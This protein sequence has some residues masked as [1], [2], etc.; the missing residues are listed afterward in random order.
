MGT[1]PP[2]VFPGN[3]EERDAFLRLD[4]T[5]RRGKDGRT[6]VCGTHALLLDERALKHLIFFRR[7]RAVFWPGGADSFN[8]SADLTTGAGTEPQLPSGPIDA[9]ATGFPPLHNGGF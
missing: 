6:V 9:P 7:C 3:V 5:C 2:S 1:W 8:N 4:C